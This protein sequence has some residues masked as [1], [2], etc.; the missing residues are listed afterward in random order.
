[1]AILANIAGLEVRQGLPGG[2][3]TIVAIGAVA[4]DVFVVEYRRYP[5]RA[6]VAVITLVAGDDVARRLARGARTVVARI[7][8][9]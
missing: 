1:M 5:K 6:C 9:P 7:A 4:C 8:A 2:L 3:D